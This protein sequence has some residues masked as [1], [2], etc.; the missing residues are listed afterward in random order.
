VNLSNSPRESLLTLYPWKTA[1]KGE[2]I[3][4]RDFRRFL[5]FW[6][7][8][9]EATAILA[10]IYDGSFSTYFP[11]LDLTGKQTVNPFFPPQIAALHNIGNLD[12]K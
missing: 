2:F 7:S 5:A 1:D 3:I 12:Q 6:I 8:H 9:H 10:E 4:D 11:K